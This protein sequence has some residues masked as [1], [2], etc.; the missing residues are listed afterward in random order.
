MAQI[1]LTQLTRWAKAMTADAACT[2]EWRVRSKA[3]RIALIYAKALQ[4]GK[5]YFIGTADD[6]RARFPGIKG[7]HAEAPSDGRKHIWAFISSLGRYPQISV[8]MVK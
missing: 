4:N 2:K 7:M 6:M 1:T 8:I 3:N 5:G